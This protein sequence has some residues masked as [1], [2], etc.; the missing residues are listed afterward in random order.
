MNRKRETRRRTRRRI[1]RRGEERREISKPKVIKHVTCFGRGNHSHSL[2][3]FLFMTN[4]FSVMSRSAPSSLYPSF[5]VLCFVPSLALQVFSDLP[6]HSIYTNIIFSP[7]EQLILTGTFGKVKMR[8]NVSSSSPSAVGGSSSSSPSVA[9]S[10]SASSSALDSKDELEKE[11]LGGVDGAEEAG[12]G[13]Q[14]RVV[15]IRRD[16]LEIIHQVNV[17]AYSVVSLLWHPRINQVHSPCVCI[18][19]ASSE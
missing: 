19:F 6:S 1:C 7:D 9:S 13:G 3:R 15:M 16:T 11:G 2:V 10:S 17:S 18:M 14:G 12:G 8:S 5:F 4:L